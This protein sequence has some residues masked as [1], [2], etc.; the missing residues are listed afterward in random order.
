[1]FDRYAAMQM[2]DKHMNLSDHIIQEAFE[3]DWHTCFYQPKVESSVEKVTGVEALFRLDIP[4]EGIFSP[5]VF[6]DRAFALG[7][8]EE[9]FFSVLVQ[10]LTEVKS[11]FIHLNL[12]E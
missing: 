8:E 3:N 1:M 6:I 12:A 2:R 9:I 11:L 7:Y 5:G 4:E 10:S